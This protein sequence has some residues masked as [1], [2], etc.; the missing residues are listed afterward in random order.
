MVSGHVMCHN[1]LP[2]MPARI[3]GSL[4]FLFQHCLARPLKCGYVSTFVAVCRPLC[5]K[6]IS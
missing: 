2:Q 5:I 6:D 1:A 3:A 4:G